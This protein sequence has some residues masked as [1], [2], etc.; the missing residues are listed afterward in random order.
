MDIPDWLVRVFLGLAVLQVLALVPVV[1][2][3]RG[4]DSAVRSTAR[5]D[6][7]D[8]VGGLLV[9]GGLI[10]S[11]V[12]AESWIW[13]GLAGFA[14]VIAAYAVKGVRLLRARRRFPAA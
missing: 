13:V 1:R 10:L 2:R 8:T 11:L 5:L 12:R 9:F 14:L 6:L 4:S 7:L 3:L